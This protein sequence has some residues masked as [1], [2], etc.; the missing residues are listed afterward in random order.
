VTLD[1]INKYKKGGKPWL[2]PETL[3]LFSSF[4]ALTGSKLAWQLAY[5]AIEEG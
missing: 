2:F 1:K 5:R 4:R 3:K